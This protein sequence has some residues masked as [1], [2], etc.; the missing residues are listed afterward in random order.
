MA[1]L[2]HISSQPSATQS[3]ST[4]FP[5]ELRKVRPSRIAEISRT[6]AEANVPKEQ[7]I[8]FHIGNPI[9]D[10]YL[11]RLYNLLISGIDFELTQLENSQTL[12]QEFLQGCDTPKLRQLWELIFATAE[13]AIAYMPTGGY[14][15][16]APGT[17]IRQFRNWLLAGQDEALDY[18]IGENGQ[19][20]EIAIVSG[21]PQEALKLLL[22]VIEEY[23]LNE[24]KNIVVASGSL[25]PAVCRAFKHKLFAVPESSDD[26]LSE[27]EFLLR[28]WQNQVGFV[29]VRKIYPEIVRKELARLALAHQ[30]MIIEANDA[31]NAVSLAKEIGLEGQNDRVLRI[32]S[33]QA[34]D[35]RLVC[36]GVAFLMGRYDFVE[37]LNLVH[38]KK[39]GTPSATEIKLLSFLLNELGQFDEK[40][41][42][43]LGNTTRKSKQNF[44]ISSIGNNN[45]ENSH[46]EVSAASPTPMGLKQ[47][48]QIAQNVGRYTAEVVTRV[49]NIASHLSERWENNPNLTEEK[50]P[51]V[52]TRLSARHDPF[53]G[54]SA[55]EVVEEFFSHLDDPH[56]LAHLDQAFLAAFQQVHPQFNADCI[57]SLSGSARMGLSTM[58]EAWGLREAL[59]TDLSWSVEDAFPKTIAVPLDSD[60]R[61]NAERMIAAVQSR[62]ATDPQWPEYGVVVINNPHNT[63]GRINSEDAIAKILQ[64]CLEN[65]IRVI[66]DLSYFDVIIAKPEERAA[67]LPVKSCREIANEMVRQGQLS[68]TA[69][70][71]LI[72]ICSISKTDCKA[73]ARLAVY[74]ILDE[75]LRNK[76][77]QALHTVEKN[78]MAL[79]LSYLFYRRGS[80][81]VQ[82]F[83]ALRDQRMWQRMEAL[84]NAV[85]EISTEENPFELTVI[86][87]EGAMYPHLLVKR[88]PLYVSIDKIASSLAVKGIGLIPMTAFA[89]SEESFEYA[90][91]C[92]R[93]TL[94]G[95]LSA[96]KMAVKVRRLVTEL[97]RQVRRE[98]EHYTLHRLP[99]NG[100]LSDLAKHPDV[101]AHL[102]HYETQ[103]NNLIEQIYQ[104]VDAHFHK[105]A[106]RSQIDKIKD[107]R[108]FVEKYLPE[109]LEVLRVKLHDYA[110]LYCCFQ[111]KF[112]EGKMRQEVLQR[113]Y[114][115]LETES[116]K[117]RRRRFQTRLFDRTVHPT[118]IY[119]L[120][121]EELFLN[122]VK[123]I[124]YPQI[125]S[126]PGLEQIAY[127]LVQEYFGEN[128]AISSEREADEAICDIEA[129]AQASDYAFY[130]SNN[131]LEL[132]L[133]LWG[134]WDGSNRP[135]GQGHTLVSG[136]LIENV[137]R[138][139]SLIEYFKTKNLLSSDDLTV[140]AKI[141]NIESFIAGFKSTLRKITH[142]TSQLEAKYIQLLPFALP[143]SRTKKLL[144]RLGLARDPIKEMWKHND[145]NERRMRAYRQQ[146]SAEMRRLFIINTQLTEIAKNV[147]SR[148]NVKD[149]DT[150][151]FLILQHYKNPLRQ[152]FL[153][154]RIHQKIITARDQFNV[155]TTVYNLVE[156]N[157]LGAE[158]GYPG[159]V[160]SVQVS[161]ANNPDAIIV[162][163]KKLRNERERV[164]REHKG[165]TL[166]HIRI[167]PLFEEIEVLN[168]IEEFLEPLWEY[169]QENRALGQSTSERFYEFI[170]EFFIAGSDLSQQVGQLKAYS[171]YQQS[172]EKI[173]RWLWQ[174]GLLGMRNFES[175]QKS[176]LRIK[177]GSGEAAQ[178]QSGYYDP[179]AAQLVLRV[180]DVSQIKE[181]FDLENRAWVARALQ[182]ARSPLTGILHHSDFRT[183]QSNL[184]ETLRRL[185]AEE[186]ANV[187]HHIQVKQASYESRLWQTATMLRST[188]RRS[189]G[190]IP[191]L[192]NPTQFVDDRWKQLEIVVRRAETTTFQEFVE[193]ARN[194]FVQILY[195]KPED[196]V[197]I[198]VISY[199]LSRTLLSVRDRPGIRPTRETGGERTRQI[200]ERLS[201]T[202]PLATHG[203][204]LR[205][206]EHNKS[207]TFVLGFNQL[208]TGV[209]R[210]IKEFIDS[211]GQR[212]ERI[213][214]L[215]KFVFPFIPVR[216]LLKSL[217]LYHDPELTYTRRVARSFPP[218]NSAI[219]V[220]EEDN[221]VIA[222]ILPLLQ[223][224]LIYQ[225]GLGIAKIGENGYLEPK[226]LRYVRPDLAVLMQKDLFNTD[227]DSFLESSTLT[228]KEKAEFQQEFSKRIIIKNVRAQMWQLLEN[229]ISEQ[230]R[231]FMELAL[232]IKTLQTDRQVVR[233]GEATVSKSQ[234]A[235][236]GVQ[237]NELLRNVAD[238]SMRQFLI[239]AVQFLMH[240][241]E[242]MEEIPAEV[243]KALRDVEKIL[244]LEE[245]A[246]TKPQQKYLIFLFFKIARTAGESG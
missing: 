186:L 218:G 172:R 158:H 191:T 52:P 207:Q 114:L 224:F 13:K 166:P 56:F 143:T 132:I 43:N 24:R 113:F 54:L 12:L 79:L 219:R 241:P 193:I 95:T 97:T 36:T 177:F 1:N 205:A 33:P 236:L 67:R 32:V 31:S 228:P 161:M 217:R 141:G 68:I 155:N 226:Y 128:V 187:L 121:V 184:M 144:R 116:E 75:K 200:V 87:A 99:Q 80:E 229:P 222:E 51:S 111:L 28:Q 124:L 37:A 208:S 8:E 142:L 201:G 39:K 23:L 244:K 233:V 176:C 118:Q 215:Q 3:V 127:E 148:L 145:R 135:S 46:E 107:Y 4:K 157:R 5:F 185:S 243:F 76:F 86:P 190:E 90:N 98:V 162:L 169:C 153:T 48:F 160:M 238:D 55:S 38:F 119:S 131:K 204:L 81:R 45:P 57:G 216:D 139:S 175:G 110:K 123:H 165:L 27:V 146:R 34:I 239:T 17:L 16:K 211:Q 63:T 20:T 138:L 69:S 206:I 210:A 221:H 179:N 159:V 209:F 42:I 174:K 70:T 6:A 59:I 189:L 173:Y 156:L 136:A 117:I 64:F 103:L 44:P 50:L 7:K 115:E 112:A 58:V 182:Q 29:L 235:K 26:I 140:L 137:K 71:Y 147:V 231:S 164:M 223:Q 163:D 61:L 150:E 126:F 168:H 78:R 245:E 21:G 89:R 49:A 203:T 62:L 108:E 96:N 53:A 25:D 192:S 19:P 151:L 102:Q 220:L 83:W 134:D 240:L 212:S 122:I 9:Q 213:E 82:Q 237:V 74:E 41:W 180:Q 65:G 30:V 105:W 84:Q 66:D 125:Y 188:R 181:I 170:G 227:F 2:S 35:P 22:Q 18:S 60:L 197:G 178:R 14:S 10:E 106:P 129:L 15:P 234:I 94:G 196:M 195:G 242:S 198:H 183:F 72:T 77:E 130:F 11:D 171:V 225:Q 100:V 93:L 214:L 47:F 73:G 104:L 40:R 101:K 120:R 133:S 152:F 85:S 149:S 194:N 91:R 167:V 154:P 202:L 232:A 92:F 199:F 246:L 109:R 88:M 230:V